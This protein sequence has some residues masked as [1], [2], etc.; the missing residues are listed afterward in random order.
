M[1]DEGWSVKNK[2]QHQLK[3]PAIQRG[4]DRTNKF[5]LTTL[6][7]AEVPAMGP[8]QNCGLGGMQRPG[9]RSMFAL[10]PAS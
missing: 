5:L 4:C 10:P 9:P 6:G 2:T 1:Y 7:P 3:L 8:Q